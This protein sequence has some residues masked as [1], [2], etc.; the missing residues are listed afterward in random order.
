MLRA[1]VF[2]LLGLLVS[3][4]LVGCAGDA[5]DAGNNRSDGGGTVPQP[6]QNSTSIS[7]EPVAGNVV[8]RAFT[9]KSISVEQTRG[10]W[11]ITFRNYENNCGRLPSDR[12]PGDEMSVVTIG[13]IAPR[14]GEQSIAYGDSHAATFQLGVYMEGDKK[15]KIESA[16]TGRLVF[17]SFTEEP[18]AEIAGA[19]VLE[20]EESKIAGRFS[21]RVCPT[22]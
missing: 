17:D 16:H 5:I 8:G 22:R 11:L 13:D 21:A 1:F 20:G 19:I 3:P 7:S 15:P 4:S 14:A 12:P 18:N 2:G 10:Q 9:P 6:A